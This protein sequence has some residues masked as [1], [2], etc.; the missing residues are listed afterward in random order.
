MIYREMIVLAF[1]V[2]RYFNG[3]QSD[4]WRKIDAYGAYRSVKKKDAELDA[5]RAEIL[6]LR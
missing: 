1:D 6:T 5:K 3:Q 4:L 2:T